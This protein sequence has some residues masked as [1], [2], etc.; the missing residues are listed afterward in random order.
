MGRCICGRELTDGY[1]TMSELYEHRHILL[2][3]FV[4]FV[5]IIYSHN[6]DV[7]TEVFKSR[8]HSDN[9]MFDGMFIVM[10]YLDGM[11]FSYHVENRYWN[12][13]K[14]PEQEMAD[15]WDGHTSNDVLKI[16]SEWV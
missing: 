11:Q 14:I 12:M 4:N 1:H 3:G 15:E 5:N 2:A 8:L 7:G 6:P 13:F 16:I 10:G 9:T